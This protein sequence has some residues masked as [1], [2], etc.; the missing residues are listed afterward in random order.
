MEKLTYIHN[1]P[2]E[3]GL[4][5]LPWEYEYSLATNYIEKHSMLEVVLLSA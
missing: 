1:N 3:H 4:C 5:N 2:V